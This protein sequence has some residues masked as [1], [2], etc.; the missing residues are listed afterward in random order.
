MREETMSVVSHSD[1]GVDAG[2]AGS[3]KSVS[4]VPS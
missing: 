3:M 4:V 1:G 2:L